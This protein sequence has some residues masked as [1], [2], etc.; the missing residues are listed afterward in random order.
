MSKDVSDI[1]LLNN[2][3]TV[4]PEVFKE[5][6]TIQLSDEVIAVSNQ[7]GIGDIGGFVDGSNQNHKADISK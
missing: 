6:E 1:I 5:G 7:W 4:M 2:D 3:F